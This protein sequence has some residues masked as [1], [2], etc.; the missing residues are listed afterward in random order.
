MLSVLELKMPE[1]SKSNG[2]VWA[3]RI[4][5]GNSRTKISAFV[6][7]L[8]NCRAI[9]VKST[10]SVLNV[11]LSSKQSRIWKTNSAKKG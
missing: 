9:K 3:S 5:L 7:L 10:T 1:D 6:N 8:H 4:S 11:I 2:N